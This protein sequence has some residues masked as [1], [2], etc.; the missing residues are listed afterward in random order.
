MILGSPGCYC[1]GMWGSTHLQC[2]FAWGSL[3]QGL[4]ITVKYANHLMCKD[5]AI[6]AFLLDCLGLKGGVFVNKEAGAPSQARQ[7]A[8]QPWQR[9]LA[10]HL[11]GGWDAQGSTLATRAVQG[12]LAGSALPQPGITVA[13]RKWTPALRQAKSESME[14]F[15]V[16]AEYQIADRGSSQANLRLRGIPSAGVEPFCAQQSHCNRVI[17][18]SGSLC[19]PP[20]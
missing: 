8:A 3:R 13:S 17:H 11:N 5:F 16:F 18:G 4:T 2:E 14:V 20:C 6:F 15:A 19:S 7:Q 12:H 9:S 1:N 10:V